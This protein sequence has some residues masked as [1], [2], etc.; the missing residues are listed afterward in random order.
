MGRPCIGQSYECY[1]SALKQYRNAC[2]LASNAGL[3]KTCT[4][5]SQLLSC[6][7]HRQF[8]NIINSAT[9][10]DKQRKCKV[11]LDYLEHFY[12]DKFKMNSNTT[13]TI[14]DNETMVSDKFERLRHIHFTSAMISDGTFMLTLCLQH[15]LVPETFLH[16]VLIPIYNTDKDSSKANSYRHVTLSVTLTK[17]LEIY[18][19][20]TC[21]VHHQPHPAQFGFTSHR[22]TD[23]A[24]AVAHDVSQY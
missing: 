9:S 6:N 11:T 17:I 22:G 10:Y 20:E 3:G 12:E 16:G 5:T 21:S 4:K 7:I 15:G 2:R 8:W 13:E 14:Q 19:L 24:I 1:K 18:I 23:M